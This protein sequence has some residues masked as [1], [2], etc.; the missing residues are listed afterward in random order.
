MRTLLIL[1]CAQDI[2]LTRRLFLRI[3]RL[4]G[5]R[6]FS[7]LHLHLDSDVPERDVETVLSALS[8]PQIQVHVTR[9]NEPGCWRSKQAETML[10][11]YQMACAFD[12]DIVRLDPDVFIPS[13]DFFEHLA[14]PYDGIAGKLMLLSPPAVISGRQLDFIQGGVS[15]WG[16]HGRS[17][18]RNSVGFYREELQ[19]KLSHMGADFLLRSFQPI[20]LLFSLHRGCC[21]D[22]P[23]GNFGGSSSENIFQIFRSALTMCFKNIALTDGT[24]R[25]ILRHSKKAEHWLI[26]L[27]E[28]TRARKLR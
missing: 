5:W 25:I 10:A 21:P 22:G 9:S 7:Y 16:P 11:V 26:T 6:Y 3:E 20:R 1:S 15:C 27:K 12:S 28:I 14:V 17:F 2:M 8:V 19:R 13:E 23:L 4:G 24:T 18:L